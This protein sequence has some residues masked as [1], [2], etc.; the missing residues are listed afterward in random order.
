VELLDDLPLVD[1][2]GHTLVGRKCIL[3]LAVRAAET[4]EV[5]VEAVDSRSIQLVAR[6]S[7]SILEATKQIEWQG[8]IPI[9]RQRLLGDRRN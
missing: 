3:R 7:D 1:L 8:A 6:R 4:T 9:D 5:Q 2:P